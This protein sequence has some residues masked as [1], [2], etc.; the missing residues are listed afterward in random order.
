MW[1]GSLAGMKPQKIITWPPLVQVLVGGGGGGAFSQI[2]LDLSDLSSWARLSFVIR[3]PF[4]TQAIWPRWFV[5][6]ENCGL[7]ETAP[8]N[9]HILFGCKTALSQGRYRWQH[10]H[11]LRKLA[12]L[13]ESM[14]VLPNKK[15]QHHQKQLV[16][17]V[18]V[19]QSVQ[20]CPTQEGTSGLDP[21]NDWLMRA[22]KVPHWHHPAVSN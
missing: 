17:F 7:C 10:D 9:H 8:V 11:M 18:I 20:N 13:T 14:R 21:G 6:E 22:A 3:H 5:S 12:L 15:P 2:Q 16:H 1:E 19:G 4:L